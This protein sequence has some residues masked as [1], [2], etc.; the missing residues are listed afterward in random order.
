LRTVLQI[1]GVD[2]GLH[3]ADVAGS[4]LAVCHIHSISITHK[5]LTRVIITSVASKTVTRRIPGAPLHERRRDVRAAEG[6]PAGD[7]EQPPGKEW[8]GRIRK[9]RSQ[10]VQ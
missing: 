9:H 2:E 3:E 5:H 8:P 4:C 1:D 7:G 6:P 10:P